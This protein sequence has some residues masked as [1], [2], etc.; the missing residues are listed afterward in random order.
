ML[1]PVRLSLQGEAFDMVQD[2]NQNGIT[3]YETSYIKLTPE[4]L[5]ALAA[6]EVGS[7]TLQGK[8]KNYDVSVQGKNK[9]YDESVNADGENV[10]AFAEACGGIE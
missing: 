9:C 8:N 4:A 3:M 1:Q 7:I 6:E 5:E 10:K 2:F